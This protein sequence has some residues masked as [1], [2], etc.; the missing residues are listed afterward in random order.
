MNNL[1]HTKKTI[2]GNIVSLIVLQGTMYL[3]PLILLPYL[4]R[5]LGIENFGLLAFA[6]ATIA[7]LRGIVEYGFN[8]TG[9]QQI[10]LHRNDQEQVNIIFSSIII[11]KFILAII[12]FLVLMIIIL[13]FEK[14][15]VNA[16]LFLFTFLIIFGDILFPVWFFQGIEKMKM[17]T[18]I[19]IIYKIVFLVLVLL[20]VKEKNDYLLVPIFDSIGLI[21]SAIISLFIVKKYYNIR[22]KIS[23]FHEISFQFKDSW[24]VFLSR[25]AVILY[26]SINTFLLGIFT[27]SEQVGIYSIAEKIYM[28][29]RGILNPFVQAVFPFLNRK[30]KES[31]A[32][33]YKLVKKV[34][35]IYISILVFFSLTLLTFSGDIVFVVAGVYIPQSD[36]LLKIFAVS[37]LFGIG[38]LY[39]SLLIIKNEKSTLS[40]VTFI[41]MI[42]NVVLIYPMLKL[43]GIFG[44]AYLFLIIQVLQA[45]LQTNYNKEI[46]IKNENI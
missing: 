19:F 20:L 2:I 44:V 39:S 42:C 17:I 14:F 16:K 26:T 28:A 11:S 38:T 10:S 24:H 4:I 8:L 23:K 1:S 30:Y 7:F 18:Y 25:I 41:T 21:V 40:K 22:F 45:L 15:Q 13:I 33:Y 43:F 9:T 32:I 31:K 5:V 3:I 37:I 46:W 6:T 35:I 29:L 34:S 36:S 27:N 12:C